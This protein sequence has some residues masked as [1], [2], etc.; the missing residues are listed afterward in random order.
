MKKVMQSRAFILIWLPVFL[1]LLTGCRQSETKELS[2]SQPPLFLFAYNEEAPLEIKESAVDEQDG[3]TIH[4]HALSYTVPGNQRVEAYLAKPLGPGPFPGILMLHGQGADRDQL[5]NLA[6]RL[7]EKGMAS[8]LITAHFGPTGR[9]EDR[10]KFIEVIIKLRRAIDLLVTRPE[11]DPD[12]VGYLG[13]D[14]GADAG[15]VLAGVDK[16]LKAYV[17]MSGR[18][19]IGAWTSRY[20]PQENREEYIELMSWIDPVNYVGQAAPAALF[21]Q[22]GNLDVE[23]PLREA[24]ILTQAGSQPKRVDFYDAY[25]VL[26]GTA[27]DDAI[28]WLDEQLGGG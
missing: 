12:R 26:P 28:E 27:Y 16:R 2:L 18:A 5:L 17:L 23:V 13:F 3:V 8:L 4:V 24:Q 7:A 19:R 20:A 21:F 10:E 25:H 9:W 15:A 14:D 22:H 6:K 1:T 11:V